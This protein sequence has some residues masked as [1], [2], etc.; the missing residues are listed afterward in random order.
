MLT[1]F[2]SCELKKVTSR[3]HDKDDDTQARAWRQSD[4]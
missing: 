3:T 4:R 1:L 2:C